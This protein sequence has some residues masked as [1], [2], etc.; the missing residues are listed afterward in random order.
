MAFTTP[1]TGFIA[2][3]GFAYTDINKT[4]ENIRILA[5][6]DNTLPLSTDAATANALAKR[7]ANGDIAFRNMTASGQVSAASLAGTAFGTGWPTLLAKALQYASGDVGLEHDPGGSNGSTTSYVAVTR[8][9]YMRIGGT[10]KTRFSFNGIQGI[11][12]EGHARIYKNGSA[13]GTIRTKDGTYSEDITV[14]VGDYLEVR[15]SAGRY[16]DESWATSSVSNFIISVAD[17]L[18]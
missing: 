9:I 10:I 7:D 11:S 3:E 1:K 12:I 4:N 18:I 13:V 16:Y 6:G 15:A 5:G 14:A 17:V 2:G 8:R